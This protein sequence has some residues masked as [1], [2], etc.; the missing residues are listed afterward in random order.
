MPSYSITVLFKKTTW[1]SSLTM[2]VIFGIEL[3]ISPK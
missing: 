2:I 1:R 3:R